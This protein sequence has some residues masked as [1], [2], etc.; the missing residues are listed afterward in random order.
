MINS[1][2]EESVEKASMAEFGHK[3]NLSD[4]VNKRRWKL[5]GVSRE[6]KQADETEKSLKQP[7]FPGVGWLPLDP[8]WKLP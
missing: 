4:I 8:L 3:Y 6:K 5:H 1:A 2:K 7:G